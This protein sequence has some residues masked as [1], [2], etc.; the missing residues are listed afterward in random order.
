MDMLRNEDRNWKLK[1]IENLL[2]YL[3]SS[4]AKSGDISA[5]IQRI[6]DKLE[7]SFDNWPEHVKSKKKMLK[8]VLKIQ[9]S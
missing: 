8:S 7:K 9:K 3:A 6:Q 1:D 4:E 5:L 2:Q